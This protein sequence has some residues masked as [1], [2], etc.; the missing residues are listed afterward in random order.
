M[1]SKKKSVEVHLN[2]A[3]KERVQAKA[4]DLVKQGLNEGKVDTLLGNLGL[5]IDNKPKHALFEFN[6]DTEGLK[7]KKVFVGSNKD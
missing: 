7:G 3:F 5:F 1:N 2:S 4:L 6:F